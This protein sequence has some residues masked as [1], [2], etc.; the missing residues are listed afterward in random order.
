M[1]EQF[2][3]KRTGFPLLRLPRRET[4]SQCHPEA[5]AE[6]SAFCTKLESLD[7]SPAAQNDIR[8]ILVLRH[9]LRGGREE[10]ALRHSVN[11][12]PFSPCPHRLCGEIS[13]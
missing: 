10:E 4:G 5:V 3:T 11:L 8:V 13:E 2:T 9:S 6:G 1:S 12:I 7:S